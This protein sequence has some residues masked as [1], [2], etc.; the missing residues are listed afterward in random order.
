MSAAAQAARAVEF[1]MPKLAMAMNEGS[2]SDWAAAEGSFVAKGSALLVV[3]T[4][5]VAID[6]ESP[7]QGWLQL[8]VPKGET[9]PVD[10]PIARFHAS[11]QACAAAIAKRAGAPAMVA[12]TAAPAAQQ[13]TVVAPIAAAIAGQIDVLEPA[14]H[15]RIKA[16]PLARKMA[17]DRGLNL[18]ALKGTGPEGRIVKRDILAASE[19]AANSGSAVVAAVTAAASTGMVELARI[20]MAGIRAV[21]AQRMMQSLATTAQLTHF[22]E[23]D[24]SALLAMRAEFVANEALLGAKVS[25]NAF[26]LKALAWAVKRVPVVNAAVAGKD[27][28][29]WRNVNI[30]IA[31]EAPSGDGYTSKLMVPVIRDVDRKGVVEIDREFRELARRAKAGEIGVADM[32]DATISFTSLAGF[33]PPGSMGTPVLNLPNS[34][35]VGVGTPVDKPVVR[36]GQVVVRTMMSV[37]TTYDHRIIDGAPA[38]RFGMALHEVLQS[39][40]LMLA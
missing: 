24:I 5:K 2:V 31:M 6:V 19:A 28:V 20:P 26:L 29:I 23:S 10:T 12:E 8:L 17:E 18:R 14:A 36:D 7:F 38:G 39:P 1:G 13:S 16:S 11:E 21:I 27:M 32:A 40:A 4:E 33:T 22:W 3:E 34:M 37:N 30:G 15:G 35:I 9:V 25:V